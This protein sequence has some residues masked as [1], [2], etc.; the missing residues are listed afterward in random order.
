[1]TE[2]GLLEVHVRDTEITTVLE[3]LS[4]QARSNIVASTSVQGTVSANLYGLTLLEAL[5]AILTPSQYA[6]RQVGR[7]I[8]VGTPTEIA[9]QLPPP[10][11]RVFRLR[12]ISKAEA[13]TAVNAVLSPEG[14]VVV[15]GGTDSAGA[16]SGTK[17]D[18]R[19]ASCGP[20][21]TKTTSSASISRCWVA[22]ISRTFPASAM[23]QPTSRPD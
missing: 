22:W 20:R 19:E 17:A 18:G 7:T 15:G 4:Y 14:S 3:M 8:F 12:Y 10:Q 9:A 13:L 16:Q 2:A 11:T 5:D 6:Y 1:V 23:L 21:S